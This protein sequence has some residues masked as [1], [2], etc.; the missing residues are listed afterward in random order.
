MTD[1]GRAPLWVRALAYAMAALM[2]VGTLAL[3]GSLAVYSLRLLLAGIMALAQMAA[4]GA[5]A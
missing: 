2:A 4:G 1:G 3:V 5:W